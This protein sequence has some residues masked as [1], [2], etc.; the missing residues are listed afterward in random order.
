M[1][2][3]VQPLSQDVLWTQFC[4]DKLCGGNATDDCGKTWYW[5]VVLDKTWRGYSDGVPKPF[6]SRYWLP[7]KHKTYKNVIFFNKREEAEQWMRENE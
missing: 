5:I 4:Y 6:E 3:K 2:S 7:E 1:T